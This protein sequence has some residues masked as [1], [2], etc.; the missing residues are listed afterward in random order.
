MRQCRFRPAGR[1]L[2]LFRLRNAISGSFSVEKLYTLVDCVHVVRVVVFSICICR[3]GRE[4]GV[5][6]TC[7][8]CQRQCWFCKAHWKLS[9]EERLSKLNV[10]CVFYEQIINYY[11]L[12][13]VDAFLFIIVK[14]SGEDGSPLEKES[15]SQLEIFQLILQRQCDAMVNLG[16]NPSIRVS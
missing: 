2:F 3:A 7:S 6:G 10:T 14:T 11:Q 15:V 12:H 13:V 9:K 1:A 16:V 5:C 8:G 4:G